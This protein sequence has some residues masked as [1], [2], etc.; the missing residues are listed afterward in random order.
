MSTAGEKFQQLVAIMAR[1]RGPGGCPWDREQT[2]DTIKP[3]T[4]EETYEVI[5]A[6]DRRDWNEV[7]EELG[8]LLLQVVFYAQMAEEQKLFDIGAALDAVNQKLIRRHPHVFGDETAQTSGDVKRIWGEVKAAE[9]KDKG[10]DHTGLL[11]SVPRA[12]PALIEAQQVASRAAGVGFDWENPDQ[13]IEK[14]HEELA[15]LDEA[16]R[17]A[18]PSE[19]E[20]EIGD[21]FFVLVNLARFVKV[22]PEQALR[23]TNAKFRERFGYI[24]R[25]LAERGKKLEESNIVEME[26]L[27]QEAKR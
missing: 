7:A 2:F 3:Y 5:D 9:K 8:D 14:L 22:D 12:M 13:V 17:N 10:K 4:L 26:E 19:L 18:S 24:E 1:L 20:N 21:L 6:I 11:A 23:R 15:E 25:K 27:W 16:R